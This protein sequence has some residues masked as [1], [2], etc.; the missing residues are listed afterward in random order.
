LHL[1]EQLQTEGWA[2]VS[3][4]E[5]DALTAAVARRRSLRTA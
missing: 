3:Q 5:R 2:F 1:D 4:D